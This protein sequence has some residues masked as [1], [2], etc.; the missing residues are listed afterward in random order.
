[1][2]FRLLE[3]IPKPQV[4]LLEELGRSCTQY[5]LVARG[6]DF[7]PRWPVAGVTVPRAR[8]RL[9]AELAGLESAACDAE[10]RGSRLSASSRAR[11]RF[12]EGLLFRFPWPASRSRSARFRVAS[13]VVP[14][15]GGGRSTPARRAFDNPMAIACCGERAP[16][17]PLRICSISSRTNSPACVVGAL[18]SRLSR[19]ARSSV[20]FSG[21]VASGCLIA[22]G[23]KP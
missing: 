17:L 12:A 10:D 2:G 19:R 22:A 11:D 7:R 13:D 1:M 20:F 16:C 15:L 4:K 6:L 21:I 8:H 23:V 9:A 3:H 5:Y 14:F 18:P